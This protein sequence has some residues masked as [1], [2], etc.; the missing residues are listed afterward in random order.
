MKVKVTINMKE[1]SELKQKEMK[2]GMKIGLR[3]M[4]EFRLK[5]KEM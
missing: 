5:Q 2:V 1:M 3:E 4:S